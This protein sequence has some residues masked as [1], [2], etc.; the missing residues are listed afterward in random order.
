MERSRFEI[1]DVEALR[2]HYALTLRH[3]VSRLEERRQQALRHVSEAMYRV[4]RLYMTACALEF[5]SGG[6][7]VYQILAS[8]KRKGVAAVPLTRR[9]LYDHPWGRSQADSSVHRH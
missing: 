8:I 5:E 7:G 1:L 4:W 2:P 3:W 6:T 9:D